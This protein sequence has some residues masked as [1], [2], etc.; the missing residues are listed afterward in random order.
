MRKQWVVGSGG[1]PV[2]GATLN[3]VVGAGGNGGAAT[4][5]INVG[6]RAGGNGAPGSA[7]VEWY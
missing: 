7:L 3:I 1:A 5:N 2:P 4:G 6:D